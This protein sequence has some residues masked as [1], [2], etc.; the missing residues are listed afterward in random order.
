MA[1]PN[2][3]V[4]PP[5]VQPGAGAGQHAKAPLQVAAAIVVLLAVLAAVYAATNQKPVSAPAISSPPVFACVG[6]TW[7]KAEVS[8]TGN[9]GESVK[10]Y[11]LEDKFWSLAASGPGGP[12]CTVLAI[13]PVTGGGVQVLTNRKGMGE[14]ILVLRGDQFVTVS[15]LI[16]MPEDLSEDLEDPNAGPPG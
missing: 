7:W 1:S 15:G 2:A 10:L 14:V 9:L 13:A 6:K 16:Q 11:R 12:G 5:Q 3:G 8:R 4:A